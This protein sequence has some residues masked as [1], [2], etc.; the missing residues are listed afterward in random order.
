MH[1]H[2]DAYYKLKRLIIRSKKYTASV[3][4]SNPSRP[5]HSVIK[6]VS[7]LLQVV[8]FLWIL[9][10]PPPIKLLKVTLTIS[11]NNVKHLY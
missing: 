3:V 5:Q 1:K 2:F 7:D 4:S 9:R 11:R 8:G 6:V 10:F